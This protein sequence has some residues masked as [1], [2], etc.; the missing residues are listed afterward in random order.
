MKAIRYL[1]A[2]LVLFGIA[3]PLL[4]GVIWAT[5]LT[6]AVF[7]ETFLAGI[8]ATVIGEIPG[9]TEDLY[10]AAL[11]PGAIPDPDARAWVDAAARMEMTPPEFLR[12]IGVFQWLDTEVTDSIDAL[13]LALRGQV[14]ADQVR[15][16]MRPLKEALASPKARDYYL[17]LLAKLPQ[18]DRYQRDTW[19]LLI[20]N[21][22][23]TRGELPACT[24][25]TDVPPAAADMVLSRVVDVPDEVPLL[26]RAE[27]PWGMDLPGLAGTLVWLAFLL[28]VVFLLV[29]GSVAGTS[30][31]AFLGWTG[32]ATLLGGAVPLLTTTVVRDLA[33]GA[34]HLDQRTQWGFLERSPFWTSEAANILTRRAADLAGRIVDQLFDPVTSI[35][36]VVCAIGALL[37]GLSFVA[38]GSRND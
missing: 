33:I 38:P 21:R 3:A 27:I 34:L 9:L 22:G 2:A 10:Q 11:Q 23:V 30:R 26:Q 19:E 6:R 17:G 35:A 8:P 7:G 20:I 32:A 4:V 36:L 15:L 31:A 18:C 37:I 16:D 24:P 29:G 5:G 28:P 1:L 13:G 25:G 12:E 14:K